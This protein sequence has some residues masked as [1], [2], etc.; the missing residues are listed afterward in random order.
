MH[1]L[2]T[3]GETSTSLFPLVNSP[4]RLGAPEHW[5]FVYFILI[6]LYKLYSQVLSKDTKILK[7][8]LECLGISLKPVM[9]KIDVQ[10]LLKVI[11][12]QLFGYATGLVDMIVEHIPSPLKGTGCK[13]QLTNLVHSTF[14]SFT[15]LNYRLRA[16]TLGP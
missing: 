3:S 8:T 7:E 2:T 10:L 9:F 6:Q 4:E 12:E 16:Q 11:T 15:W 1:L 14:L 5:T 13:A